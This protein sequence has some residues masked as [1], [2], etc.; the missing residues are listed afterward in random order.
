MAVEK[1]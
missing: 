1:F